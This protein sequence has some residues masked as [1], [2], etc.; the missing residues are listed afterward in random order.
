MTNK[1]ENNL[2]TLIMG[3]VI[4][5]TILLATTL[6]VTAKTDE[7]LTE[8]FTPMGHKMDYI[9][10]LSTDI[11]EYRDTYTGI[12]YEVSTANGNGKI[13]QPVYID[14]NLSLK[15]TDETIESVVGQFYGTLT[16]VDGETLYQ[17]KSLDDSV[18]CLLTETEMRFIPSTGENYVLTYDNQGTTMGNKPCDCVPEL[19]CE[20]EL[21][22]D[23]FLGIVRE[24]ADE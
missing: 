14:E 16:T 7:P 9:Q 20:C 5:M 2:F 19:E 17:F 6:R 13:V 15:V 1:K 4:F 18:W 24:G 12:H 3:I 21:Y 10:Q 11:Y 8:M 23:V 22:D